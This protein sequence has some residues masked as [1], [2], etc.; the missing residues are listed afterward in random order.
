MSLK[1]RGEEAVVNISSNVSGVNQ[2]LSG[3]MFKVRDFTATPRTEIKE[4]DYLG[5]L[6]TDLDIQ[7]H[8]W[9]IGFTVDTTDDAAMRYTDGV[10]AAEDEHRAH[11]NNTVTVIYTFREPGVRGKIAVFTGV[12]L[13]QDEETIG[14]RKEII[15]GKFSGK[16]KRRELLAA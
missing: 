9:D 3:T 15:R 4:D 7:H 6:E 1:T 2:T 13:K 16:C 12:F 8:G 14:G 5:E 10:I 11:P